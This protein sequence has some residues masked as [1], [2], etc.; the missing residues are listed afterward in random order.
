MLG[1]RRN[2]LSLKLVRATEPSRKLQGF[3]PFLENP[4][5]TSLSEP[6]S[7]KAGSE[8]IY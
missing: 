3:P 7:Y 5:W 4:I 6:R 1:S 8:L 2:L